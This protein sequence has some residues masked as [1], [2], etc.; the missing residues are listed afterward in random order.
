MGPTIGAQYWYVKMGSRFVVISHAI[1]TVIGSYD[2][3]RI[4]IVTIGR[5]FF[6]ALALIRREIDYPNKW[7]R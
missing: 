6:C 7:A 2:L 3:I 1:L 4:L 5:N